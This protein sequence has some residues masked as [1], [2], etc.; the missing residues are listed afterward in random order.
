MIKKGILILLLMSSGIYTFSQYTGTDSTQSKARDQQYLDS[1]INYDELF[2]DFDYFM[3]SI[4]TPHSYFMANLSLSNGYYNFNS[5]TNNTVE[6]SKRLTYSPMLAYY[7]HSGFGFGMTGYILNENSKANFYQLALT[8]S[9]DFLKNKKFATGISIT[10]YF[11]KGDLSFYNSPLQNEIYGYFTWRQSWFKPTVAACYGWGSRDEYQKR[12]EIIQDIRLRRLG[13]TYINSTES[14]R[15]FSVSATLRHDFYWLDVLASNDYIRLS[16]GI[17]FTAGTQKFGFNQSSSTY[18]TIVRS[19]NN[20]LYSTDALYLD[21][22]LDFQPL[23][24]QFTIR[25]EYSIGRFFI[26][27]QY[28]LSYYFPGNEK[29]LSGLFS[30][31]MGLIF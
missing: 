12:E 10:K 2:Q 28:A 23:S 31:N 13:Y 5:K 30:L 3:D 27:P 18:A 29:K 15:D 6:A 19:R 16:P 20:V 22:Q 11:S 8:P 17:N 21:D 24:I 14:I 1:S 7:H 4:L 25:P 9:F 26:Q